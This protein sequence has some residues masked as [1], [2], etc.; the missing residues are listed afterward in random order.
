[1]AMT[2]R[3]G[4]PDPGTWRNLNPKEK[5]GDDIVGSP[6]DQER[7]WNAP[8]ITGYY[9]SGKSSSSK[10]KDKDDEAERKRKEEEAKKKAA[11]EAKKAEEAAKQKGEKLKPQ[12][13]ASKTKTET[14]ADSKLDIGR[15]NKSGFGYDKN[16][17]Y[18]VKRAQNEGARAEKQEADATVKAEAFNKDP[19]ANSLQDRSFPQATA[20]QRNHGQLQGTSVE[21]Q[22]LRQAGRENLKK[23]TDLLIEKH[24]IKGS[25]FYTGGPKNFQTIDSEREQI[26]KV[27]QE[28]T[29]VK[30]EPTGGA[31]R[32]NERDMA[33]LLS[34]PEARQY[35]NSIKSG[36]VSPEK[37]QYDTRPLGEQKA[38]SMSETAARLAGNK[39]DFSRDVE[40]VASN[41]STPVKD[42]T[43]GPRLDT[44]SNANIISRRQ[45]PLQAQALASGIRVK[46]EQASAN[47][48]ADPLAPTTRGL[49]QPG[50]YDPGLG[51]Q[52]SLDY[53]KYGKYADVPTN[54]PATSLGEFTSRATALEKD[55]MRNADAAATRQAKIA[56]G[57]LKQGVTMP[58]GDFIANSPKK[59]A[60]LETDDQ[61]IARREKE[62]GVGRFAGS[63]ETRRSPSQ[64]PSYFED[65]SRG[66]RI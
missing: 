61:R 29:G 57:T 5:E 19:Y 24:G 13:E 27:I 60:G 38:Q 6:R 55:G 65:K 12:E 42:T 10:S 26:A 47:G 44:R 40:R 37:M 49:R 28:K 59:K 64:S 9:S 14:K 3:Q 48:G 23:D 41:N 36:S 50:T 15:G 1:M 4:A 56:A 17:K 51:T 43:N 25:Q 21:A 11:E 7:E 63:M 2:P 33:N 22:E 30:V 20:Y 45:D 35:V 58:N 53:A 34:K 32:Y 8:K 66:Q 31:G 16:G 18:D 52:G 54:R 39:T 46:N 62:V